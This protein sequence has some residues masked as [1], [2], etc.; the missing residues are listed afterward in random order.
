[1]P[2][3]VL[4][5]CLVAGLAAFGR[6]AEPPKIAGNWRFQF[7][8]N[9]SVSVLLAVTN[10]DGKLVADILDSQPPLSG[11]GGKRVILKTKN[12]VAKADTVSFGITANGQEAMNY[13]GTVAPDGSKVT[14]TLKD[15]RGELV[16]LELKPSKLKKLS[17]EVDVAREDFATLEPG[18]ALFL[19]GFTIAANASE[20]KLTADEAR[21]LADKL[22]KAATPFGLRWEK[23]VAAKL[24]G[25]FAGQADFAALGLTYAQR[26]ERLQGDA[27]TI[28][29]QIDVQQLIVRA[30]EKS[31]KADEAKK[32]AANIA[33]LEAR[34]AIEY[35]KSSIPFET[36]AYAGRKA[37]SSRAAFVEF[38]TG[39][40]SPECVD[41]TAAFDAATIVYKPA[42]V[43]AV[44]YHVPAGGPDPL[45]S[46][47]GLNR[48]VG[49]FGRLVAPL[50]LVNGKLLGRGAGTGDGKARY[51][52]LCEAIDEQL[53]SK[54]GA[55]IALTIAK[56]DKGYKATAKVSEVEKPSDKVMLRFV[57]VEPK[58]RYAGSSGVRFHSHVVRGMPG[59][60]AGF[61]VAKKELEQSATFNLDEVKQ[62]L[63][64]FLDEFAKEQAEFSKPDRPLA[65]KN[66]KLVAYVQNDETGEVLNAVQVDVE[67]K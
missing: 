58:I 41:P 19:A 53:E 33:K 27:A 8:A 51:K 5:A 18:Q 32:L 31:G 42:D 61:A 65:L 23:Y 14:G 43:V 24:A 21:S 2:R 7:S 63:T 6:T 54:E 67:A 45:I 47:D 35:A 66:L 60:V 40:E 28:A 50:V 59:G 29:E 22:T 57:L 13:E 62:G 16:V 1:M 37:K 39:S 64:K 56:D 9:S 15:L 17:D 55:K 44:Q 20:K 10:D 49:L 36:P 4:A 34:D 26:L 25:S 3:F 52:Q 46:S 30:M 11:P 12:F 38:F 48:Q